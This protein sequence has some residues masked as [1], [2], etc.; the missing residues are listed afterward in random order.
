MLQF[1]YDEDDTEYMV[2]VWN[3][4]KKKHEYLSKQAL[5][6]ISQQWILGTISLDLD[7]LP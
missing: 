2:V 3:A 1:G 6:V 5:T 7:H 4:W